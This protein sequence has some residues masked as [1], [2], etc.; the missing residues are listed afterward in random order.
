MKKNTTALLI[1]LC[2]VISAASY[3]KIAALENDFQQYENRT[4]DS[5][6]RIERDINQV[7]GTVRDELEKQASLITASDWSYLDAD[8]EQQKVTV[9]ASVTAKEYHPQKTKAT[10][11]CN[12]VA[13]PMTLSNGLYIVDMSLDLFDTCN[14]TRV[15]FETDGIMQTE[16][17]DWVFT[18][19]YDYLPTVHADM[20]GSSTTINAKPAVHALQKHL[21]IDI[22]YYPNSLPTIPKLK[23][24]TVLAYLNGELYQE[25]AMPITAEQIENLEGTIV[26]NTEFKET[27][28]IPPG[29]TLELF[30]DV[31]VDDLRH[32]NKIDQ[33]TVSEEG[34]RDDG[35]TPEPVNEWWHAGESMEI[36]DL[37][38]N[39][40]YQL[41]ESRYKY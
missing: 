21:F 17:L 16:S 9:Q 2:V 12:D 27:F 20:S 39:L 32:R 31:V 8:L 36:Y 10:L 40:L 41:D 22:S 26:Y 38:D 14:V 19:R 33:I 23:S 4:D 37:D 30:V 18:P 3:V 1:F 7:S 25:F 6:S 11:Y 13:Y 34:S 15:Q 5:L 28:N 29:S 24:V 35:A